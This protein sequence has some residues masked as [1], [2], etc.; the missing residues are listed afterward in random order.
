MTNYELIDTLSLSSDDTLLKKRDLPE[1]V[2]LSD[3]AFS[4][5]IDFS[6]TPAIT[7]DEHTTMEEAQHELEFHSTHFMLVTDE[8]HHVIGIVTS[9][10]LL[11]AKPIQIIQQNRID[12]DKV[13]VNLLMTPLN[14]VP[15]FNL[16]SIALARVGNVIKTMHALKSPNAFVVKIKED[17]SKI[18]RGCFTTSQI[19][20]Q[21]HYNVRKGIPEELSN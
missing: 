20:K 3:A 14:K 17:G 21:L 7:I 1:L 2:H 19:S 18:L 15:A 11:G 13:L 16:E 10:D 8:N 4:V 6:Q 12:R 5:L 9:E